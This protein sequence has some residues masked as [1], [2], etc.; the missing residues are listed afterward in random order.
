MLLNF[1]YY[2]IGLKNVMAHAVFLTC[3]K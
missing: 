3:R 2:L 1:N